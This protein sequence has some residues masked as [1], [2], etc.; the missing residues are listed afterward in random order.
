MHQIYILESTKN[1]RYYI[2]ST[3]DIDKRL[4]EHNKNQVRSTK[5]KGPWK[6]VYLEEAE[7]KYRALHRE[8]SLK[9][10]KSSEALG[11]VITKASPSSSL[12]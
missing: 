3:K 6:L 7:T 2:G 8:R 9:D 4:K 1:G 11:K 5:H 10:L 12:V